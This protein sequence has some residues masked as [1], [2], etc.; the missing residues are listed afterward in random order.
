MLEYG[1]EDRQVEV[2]RGSYSFDRVT[3]NGYIYLS[4]LF[5]YRFSSFLHRPHRPELRSVFLSSI[6]VEDLAQRWCER[7]TI[8]AVMVIDLE[9]FPPKDNDTPELDDQSGHFR[10][11]TGPT[12]SSSC[13][14][15]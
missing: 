13:S 10:R 8:T 15:L 7:G 4:Y 5:V 9:C 2:V 3:D 11:L 14:M 6:P 12:N 1:S